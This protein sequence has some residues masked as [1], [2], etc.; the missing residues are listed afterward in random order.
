MSF[1]SHSPAVVPPLHRSKLFVPGSSPRFFEKAAA[2]P[3]DAIC[4]DLEDGVGAADK[5]TARDNVVKALREIDWR[6]K[7]VTVRVNGLDTAWCYRDVIAIVEGGGDALDAI[8]VPKVGVAADL[9]AIDTLASQACWATGRTKPVLLEGQ[10]ESALGLA[11]VNEIAGASPRLVS[12]HFGHADFSATV[13]M[14]T[15]KIGG[16]HPDY[17]ALGEL[18][19]A[20]ERQTFVNDPWH[21]PLMAT[22]TA[23]RAR[24]LMVFEG[25]YGEI[26]DLA[27]LA[28]YARRAAF[29]GCTGK[30]AIHPDQVEVINAAFAPSE[31][32]V[33]HARE[34]LGLLAEA[35]ASGQ[36]SVSHNGSLIDGVTIR[37]ARQL[38]ALAEQRRPGEA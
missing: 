10:I 13:G 11:N 17:V 28:A 15:V 1:T 21:Y 8:M 12:L 4:L 16:D 37:Q 20:G 22:I 34:L 27:G 6:G 3:A 2:G 9:Y 14:R 25:P 24:G 35:E 26:R 7:L 29:L 19:E 36:G 33:A 30:W 31:K 5:D 23:A 18:D 32:D 38:I